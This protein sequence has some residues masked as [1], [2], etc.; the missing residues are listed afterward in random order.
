[1]D[2]YIKVLATKPDDLSS[3]P[4]CTHWKERTDSYKLS[5]GLHKCATVTHTHTNTNVR[6]ALKKK[7]S[8]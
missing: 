2:Q 7:N 5:S 3:T 1:M 4:G 8:H 6:L